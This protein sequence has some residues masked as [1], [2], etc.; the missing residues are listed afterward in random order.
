MLELAQYDFDIIYRPGID[1]ADADALSRQAWNIGEDGPWK[2]AEMEKN[3]Q[4]LLRA[5]ESQLVGGDVGTSPTE[6]G[7]EQ[8]EGRKKGVHTGCGAQQKM[9]G[10]NHR[11]LGGNHLSD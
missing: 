9:E 11:E 10:V 3:E 2:P 4:D 5:A 1:N 7:R 6:E 8:R